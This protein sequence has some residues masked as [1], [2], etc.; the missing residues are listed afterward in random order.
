MRVGSLA[1]SPPALGAAFWRS[2]HIS[3]TSW[4]TDYVHIPL[5]GNRYGE[6]RTAV[7]RMIA[8]SLCGLWH[9]AGLHFVAWGAYHGLVLNGYRLWTRWRPA[10]RAEPRWIGRVA[11]TVLTFHVACIGWVLFA[12]DLPRAAVIIPRLLRLQ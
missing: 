2:W 1:G 5:G 11:A 8:M 7:N 9:G 10:P 4:I 6:G 3:R 12:A